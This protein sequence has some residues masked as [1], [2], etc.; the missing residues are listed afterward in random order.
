M[1]IKLMDEKPN[2]QEFLMGY[3]ECAAW[4]GISE[5]DPN[6][7]K[8]RDGHP[9]V[10]DFTVHEIFRAEK[11]CRDFVDSN[12][13]DLR[14][15]DM[16]RCGYDFWFTRNG[17]GTGFWDRGLGEVGDRLTEAAE[18]CGTMYVYVSRRGKLHMK[19]G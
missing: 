6:K 12:I 18:G 13:Q 10:Y 14:G 9:S 3:L 17:H 19:V 15:L 5:D 1:T 4:C 8:C 11:E 2:Y 7:N 16:K